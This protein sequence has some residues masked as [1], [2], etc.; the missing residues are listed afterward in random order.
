MHSPLSTTLTP[1]NSDFPSFWILIVS[2]LMILPKNAMM[3]N[4]LSTWLRKNISLWEYPEQKA[5][6]HLWRFWPHLTF[7]RPLDDLFSMT[8]QEGSYFQIWGI[9]GYT[10]RYLIC[11]NCLYIT[12]VMVKML[13]IPYYIEPR[14]DKIL[15]VHSHLS[16]TLT[17]FNSDF[18]FFGI[19]IVS[20]LML[21]PDNEMMLNELSTWFKK[22]I[23]LWKY[24]D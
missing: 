5:D 24:Y 21:L 2:G 18:P 12:E 10:F 22:N 1:F 9:K 16:T 17:P 7:K 14:T 20:G 13:S 4:K 15:N 23:G 3:L 19:L 8:N 6:F 11:C